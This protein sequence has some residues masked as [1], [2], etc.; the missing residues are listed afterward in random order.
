M[1]GF[2]IEFH[3]PNPAKQLEG[4]AMIGAFKVFSGLQLACFRQAWFGD[5]AGKSGQPD[6][7]DK[8]INFAM[9]D[10]IYKT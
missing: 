8:M 4:E 10:D 2:N 3:D 7:F 6:M 9:G 1:A 5:E